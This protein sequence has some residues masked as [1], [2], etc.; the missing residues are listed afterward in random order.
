MMMN[1]DVRSE[2]KHWN[3]LP[4]NVSLESVWGWETAAG[5]L[6]ARRRAQLIIRKTCLT[7]HVSSLEIGCGTGL[8]TE[9]VAGLGGPTVA[10]DLVPRFVEL[11]KKRNL[12]NVRFEVFDAYRI[13]P[14]KFGSPFDVVWG[15]SV[16]H[17]LDLERIVPKVFQ[18]LKPGGRFAFAE[19]NMRNPQIW[20]ERKIGFVR[21]IRHVSPSETAFRQ[22]ELE[23]IFMK[24]G[25]IEVESELFDFL[26]PLTPRFLVGA[27]KA[28]EKVL[29]SFRPTRSIAGSIIISGK[30]PCV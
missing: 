12:P 5:Q 30:R 27:V 29:E 16:L 24:Y 21:R 22:E 18:L 1:N 17:H 6:R 11:A 28:F 15:N 26:H 13:E 9:L 8:F 25:F 4:R 3:K 20:L 19:P 10:I 14:P 2:L 7:R 23:K